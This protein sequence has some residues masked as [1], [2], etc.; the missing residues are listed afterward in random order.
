MSLLSV[1]VFYVAFS[2]QIPF[3]YV[4]ILRKAYHVRKSVT[5]R[6]GH[7]ASSQGMRESDIA[8]ETRKLFF[9]FYWWKSERI[10]TKQPSLLLLVVGYN[11]SLFLLWYWYYELFLRVCRVDATIKVNSLMVIYMY[12]LDFYRNEEDFALGMWLPTKKM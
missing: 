6:I 3:S 11:V 10:I 9:P 4:K 2:I 12:I 8:N 7:D 1:C 5:R